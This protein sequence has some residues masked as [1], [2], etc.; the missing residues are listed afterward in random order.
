LIPRRYTPPDQTD[1]AGHV[2]FG[3]LVLVTL[4]SL[5]VV[6]W[7]AAGVALRLIDLALSPGPLLIAERL[8]ESS[9]PRWSVSVLLVA[10]PLFLGGFAILA[11]RLEENLPAVRSRIAGDLSMVDLSVVKPKVDS[12]QV[13]ETYYMGKIGAIPKLTLL[14]NTYP[15]T[16]L[17]V[18]FALLLVFSLAAFKALKAVRAKR[19]G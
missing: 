19:Q 9:D 7:H 3:L 11:P 16:T 4:F 8:N 15:W 12:L 18:L 13:G 2:R 14:I 10:L 6:M 1:F 5:R 17:G